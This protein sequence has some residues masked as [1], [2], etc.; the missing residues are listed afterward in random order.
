M[1]VRFKVHVH[2]LERPK[3]GEVR[4]RCDYCQEDGMLV[5]PVTV[6]SGAHRTVCRECRHPENIRSVR[7][8]LLEGM[9]RVVRQ[10]ADKPEQ[11]AGDLKHWVLAV[12]LGTDITPAAILRS[13]ELHIYAVT[14]E[15][16]F[17]EAEERAQNWREYD[18]RIHP[19]LSI[20]VADVKEW[21]E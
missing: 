5:K 9:K 13:E 20:E 8:E 11:H 17:K 1:Q 15:E 12:Q 4:G 7:A 19:I 16:A 10:A 2:E 14:R 18:E 6:V 3:R 21:H